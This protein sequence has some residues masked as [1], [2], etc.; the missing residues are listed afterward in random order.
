MACLKVSKSQSFS[1]SQYFVSLCSALP[2]KLLSR[3]H[4][5]PNALALTPNAITYNNWLTTSTSEVTQN[6][7]STIE[8]LSNNTAFE[9][10]YTHTQLLYLGIHFI[11][12]L[13]NNNA[14]LRGKP[15]VPSTCYSLLRTHDVKCPVPSQWSWPSSSISSSI[16]MSSYIRIKRLVSTWHPS[17]H[18][19][20]TGDTKTNSQFILVST[21]MNRYLEFLLPYSSSNVEA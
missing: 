17:T 10:A 21:T 13:H 4:A 14:L 18:A 15:S 16:S 6:Q 19:K 2:H 1:K 20:R 7:D 12:K 11:S 3:S 8:M 5:C 9:S